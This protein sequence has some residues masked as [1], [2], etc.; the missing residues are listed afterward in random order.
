MIFAPVLFVYGELFP[1]NLFYQA[2]YRMLRAAA[3]LFF[4]CTVL[5]LPVS[6][7]LWVFSKLLEWLLGSSPQKVQ[8]NLARKELRRVIEEGHQAGV[9][10]PAQRQLAQ[11]LFAVS[12]QP[13]GNFA[14]PISRTFPLPSTAGK[15]EALDL[16]RRNRLSNLLV[17]DA[18][19]PRRLVGYLNVAEFTLHESDALEPLRALM[20]VQEQDTHIAA[21]MAMQAEEEIL[22]QVVNRQGRVVGIVSAEDLRKPLMGA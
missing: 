7:V 5:F 20:A 13:V 19:D 4:C 18:R 1:K 12:H 3:P 15:R 21:L 2:P 6:A 9:L 10:R 17:R 11:G 14:V 8:F 16:A 22:A